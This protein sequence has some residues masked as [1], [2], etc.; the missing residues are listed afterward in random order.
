VEPSNDLMQGIPIEGKQVSYN[1]FV[2]PILNGR[3]QN[4]M[5]VVL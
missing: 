2:L 5:K 3:S 1:S 4:L